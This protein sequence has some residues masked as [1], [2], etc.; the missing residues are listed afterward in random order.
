[1]ES[2][3]HLRQLHLWEAVCRTY[4]ISPK[5]Q[6]QVREWILAGTLKEEMERLLPTKSRKTLR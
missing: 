4:A 3:L 6:Q 2:L 5:R 1:M